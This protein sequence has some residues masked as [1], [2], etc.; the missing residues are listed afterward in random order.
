MNHINVND[1]YRKKLLEHSDWSK[2][3]LNM[4]DE[5]GVTALDEAAEVVAEEEEFVEEDTDVEMDHQCP[6]CQ[7]EISEDV[8]PGLFLEHLEKVTGLME[9]VEYINENYESDEDSTLLGALAY[10]FPDQFEDFEVVEEEFEEE[11]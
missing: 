6:V 9:A 11:E 5:S 10:V 1:D 3:G 8:D 4:S 2:I 7:H